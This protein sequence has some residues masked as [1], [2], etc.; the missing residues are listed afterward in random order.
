MNDTAEKLALIVC[1]QCSRANNE[2]EL[3]FSTR[4]FSIYNSCYTNITNLI[5]KEKSKD[6]KPIV[7]II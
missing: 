3:E 4:L 2:S 7:S 1:E 6:G 5:D